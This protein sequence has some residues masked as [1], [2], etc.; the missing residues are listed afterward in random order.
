MKKDCKELLTITMVNN[1]TAQV[2]YDHTTF[3]ESKPHV[4]HQS[5]WLQ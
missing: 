3:T 5:F 4:K 1:Y 2:E